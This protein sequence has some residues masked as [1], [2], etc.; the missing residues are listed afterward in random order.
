[1]SRNSE[2]ISRPHQAIFGAHQFL[3][4][5]HWT[6]GD[7]QILDIVVSLGLSSFEISLGDDVKFS[8]LSAGEYAK[9]LG[10]ELTVGPGN[11]WPADCNISASEASHRIRGLAWH[12]RNIERAAALGARAYCGAI[13]SHPGH[14]VRSRPQRD[15]LLH[16]AE[17]L[18]QL[19]E[20]ANGFDVKL[21]IEPMSRFRSH[22]INTAK[23][24]MELIGLVR[25][26]SLLVNLDT[27]HMVTE[28]R[29]YGKAIE[30]AL[31][32][33]WGIHA[34]ENDRG[35]PGSGLVP[36]T[37]VFDSLAKANSPLRI[38]FETYNTGPN[39]FGFSRGIFQD[40]CPDPF[41][42]IV[43]GMEFLKQYTDVPQER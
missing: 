6:D 34:C 18:S 20:Y 14:V 5:S 19:A 9:S 10:I 36:W 13:Y 27:Y 16:A 8:E 22:L 2:M 17:N 29:D 23:Q 26:P 42:Y 32:S 11:I 24:A 15:E 25:H 4:K 35:V 41:A 43:K 3:W 39:G 31:P 38:V 40:V 12:R 30:S 21:V 33:L 37:S 28:E 7:L 1:M